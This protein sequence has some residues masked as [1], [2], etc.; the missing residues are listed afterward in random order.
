MLTRF[1]AAISAAFLLATCMCLW[2][3]YKGR[4]DIALSVLSALCFAVPLFWWSR[5]STLPP[6]TRLP[7]MPPSR[8][9]RGHLEVTRKDFF[10]GKAMEWAK[11]YGTIFRLRVNL[12]YIVV[13]NDI[14]S[15]KS[16]YSKDDILNR[17]SCFLLNFENYP[18]LAYLNGETWAANKRFCMSTL[19]NIGFTTSAGED[20]MRAEVSRFT[21]RIGETKGEAVYLHDPLIACITNNVVEFLLGRRLRDKA[22][23]QQRLHQIVKK[24]AL[25]LADGESLDFM[26]SI[27]RKMPFTG[28]PKP[29]L[30][31]DEMEELILTQMQEYDT[32]SE[33]DSKDD[34]VHL[35]LKKIE[36]TKCNPDSPFQYR[37][38]VGHMGSFIV[39]GTLS[40]W[41]SM[42]QTFVLLAIH[43]DTF[44][45]RVQ[46]E[47]D[48]IVG[49]HRCP[50][51]GDR[52][53]M[54]FTLAWLWEVER[55]K[56]APISVPRE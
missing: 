2:L 32:T 45:R 20:L 13:L 6:E 9:I 18:G 15:I 36:E 48:D 4:G 53:S 16:F 3:N 22:V 52:K 47:I 50:T 56:L 12:N 28:R 8:S 24:L 42:Q 30:A 40:P 49:P 21:Q 7:P 23:F 10:S 29:L 31:L 55:W 34:F 46:Q 38:L 43:K 39:G 19:K 33:A 25:S 1:L 37:F 54:P 17:S 27:A 11:A 5:K 14:E 41:E 51:W 44:Q 26:P 35:Y